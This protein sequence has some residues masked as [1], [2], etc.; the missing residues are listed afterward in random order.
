MTN[1]EMIKWYA[2][3]KGYTLS[4]RSSDST[5]RRILAYL[6]MDLAQGILTRNKIQEIKAGKGLEDFY[7]LLNTD[8]IGGYS[9]PERTL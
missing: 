5:K 7:K 3:Y 1:K 6:Y 8:F 9:L 4:T 2:D